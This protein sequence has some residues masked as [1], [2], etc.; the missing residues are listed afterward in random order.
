MNRKNSP[1][2]MFVFGVMVI[3]FAQ[4]A[5]ALFVPT[6]IDAPS[7]DVYIRGGAHAGTNYSTGVNSDQL[8]LKATSTVNSRRKSYIKFDLSTLANPDVG[9][10]TGVTFN[11]DFV[12][13]GAGT[14]D[15]STEW[16]FEVY[17]LLDS[18]DNNWSEGGATWNNT[19]AAPAG[20][21]DSNAFNLTEVYGGASLIS[22]TRTGK[23]L[24]AVNLSNSN[25][26]DFLKADTNEEVSF[27]IRRVTSEVSP[28]SYV[29]ALAANG[30]IAG[31]PA[32]LNIIQDIQDNPVPAPGSLALL[33]VGLLAIVRLTASGRN[34]N[35]MNMLAA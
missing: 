35:G 7:D 10:I 33:L 29:H 12:D 13:S 2:V 25:F 19:I 4:P 32:S 11:I 21:V 8:R 22:F 9:L 3:G 31:D 14:D 28:I 27:L 30:S 18:L 20:N 6:D 34:S 15:G 26:V 17:G 1:F 23:G 16:T 24:G 5:S